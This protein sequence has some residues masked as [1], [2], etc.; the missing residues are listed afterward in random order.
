MADTVF[1]RLDV[2]PKDASLNEVCEALG[3]WVRQRAGVVRRKVAIVNGVTSAVARM[4]GYKPDMTSEEREWHFREAAKRI[5]RIVKGKERGDDHYCI[6]L[7][8]N[9]M[10]GVRGFTESAKMYEQGICTLAKRLPL[11]DWANQPEQRGFG[12]PS[13]G[14]IIGE[15]GDLAKYAGP[16]KLWRRMGCAPFEARGENRMGSTWSRRK[17]PKNRL[18]S[19]EWTEF[20]YSKRRR[21]AMY[22]VGTSLLRC[23]YIKVNGGRTA[24][25]DTACAVDLDVEEPDE[26]DVEEVAS[27]GKTRPGCVNGP[28][29]ERY[30]AVKEAKLALGDED[31]WP[32]GRCHMHAMLLM[33]KRLLLTMWCEWNPTLVRD[34]AQGAAP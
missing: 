13:L 18:T 28:Y 22:V 21:S 29:R 12:L 3:E 16:A 4:Y 32:L 24:E 20:G 10:T 33:V 26:L 5:K 6:R 17:P 30:I 8:V 31:N 23:N 19:D 1:A 7:V 25:T 34:M 14:T 15:A 9:G 11:A 2:M 27:I